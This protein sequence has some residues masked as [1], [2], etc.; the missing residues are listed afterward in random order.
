MPDEF[1]LVPDEVS[2]RALPPEM[3]GDLRVVA[4]L[5]EELVEQ[6]AHSLKAE[7][8]I[9]TEDRVGDLVQHC[10]DDAYPWAK[11]RLDDPAFRRE[12][13]IG[14]GDRWPVVLAGYVV[15]ALNRAVELI[16]QAPYEPMRGDEFFPPR[17]PTVPQ[18]PQP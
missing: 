3:V 8:G 4:G 12:M 2:G 7:R 14:E 9:L 16:R 10:F 15:N 17:P 11:D 18:L 13:G 5:D 6:L 1:L